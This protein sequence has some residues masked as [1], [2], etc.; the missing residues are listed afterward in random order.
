MR[1]VV[2]LIIMSGCRENKIGVHAFANALIASS[3]DGLQKNAIRI[4][5]QIKQLR[6]ES[7]TTG[8]GMKTS[9]RKGK[10]GGY[11]GEFEIAALF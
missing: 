1:S 9:I 3:H 10:E 8:E 7:I 11:E 6:K 2:A 5:S 4:Q